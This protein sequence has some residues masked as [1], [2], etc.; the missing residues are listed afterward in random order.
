V[1]VDAFY[2]YLGARSFVSD[3][4]R[5]YR[6]RFQR[7]QNK[8]FTFLSHD[9]VPWNNN[10]AENAIKTLARLRNVIERLVSEATITEYLVLL[11]VCVTC[12]YKGIGVLD[13]LRSGSKDIDEYMQG[14]GR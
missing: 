3:V 10:N 4:C 12:R 8:L 1:R 13:F 7:N 5:Q 9:D 14:R 11:S 6:E 2:Q